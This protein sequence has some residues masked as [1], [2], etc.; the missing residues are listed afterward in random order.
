MHFSKFIQTGSQRKHQIIQIFVNETN[1]QQSGT[2]CSRRN[3]L[4]KVV[5]HC[6]LRRES[7]EYQNS[8]ELDPNH[9]IR[10][11]LLS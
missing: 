4:E 9:E 11:L 2:V 10:Q 3:A 8:R 7:N 6:R 5:T 1:N